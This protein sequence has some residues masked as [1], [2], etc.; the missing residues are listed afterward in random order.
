M[1]L[2]PQSAAPA[3]TIGRPKSSIGRS[4]LRW[5]AREP[6]PLAPGEVDEHDRGAE[7]VAEQEPS[8]PASR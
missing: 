7:E 5:K 3:G 4:S 6:R 8:A 1:R 2:T